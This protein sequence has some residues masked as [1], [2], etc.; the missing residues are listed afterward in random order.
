MEQHFPKFPE[1]GKPRTVYPNFREFVSRNF[2]SFFLIFRLN[3]SQF[4]KQKIS[5]CLETFQRRFRTIC[6]RFEVLELLVEWKAPYKLNWFSWGQTRPLWH[7]MIRLVLWKKVKNTRESITLGKRFSS[8][9]CV[10]D[11]RFCSWL[12]VF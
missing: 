6:P 7:N 2:R 10:L 1:R 3:G 5:D 11:N 4:E 9:Q 8:P 12:L